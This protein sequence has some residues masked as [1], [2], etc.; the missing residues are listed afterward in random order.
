MKGGAIELME[1]VHKNRMIPEDK[2]SYNVRF[3]VLEH[4]ILQKALHERT[5]VNRR[6][7]IIS[8]HLAHRVFHLEPS[9]LRCLAVAATR[10]KNGNN[11]IF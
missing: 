8:K 11:L 10:S 4:A 5:R 6:L 9:F 2:Y 3:G 7:T 1:R